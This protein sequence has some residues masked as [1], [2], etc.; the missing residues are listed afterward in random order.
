M[1]NYTIIPLDVEHVEEI[2]LDI[3]EQYEKGISTCALFSMPL[4]PEGNPVINKAQIMCEK[5]DLFR[6]RLAQMGIECGILV[7]CSIGHGY[8]LNSMF[9]F[10]PYVGLNNGEETT[11]CCPYDEDFRE[12][13]KGVMSILASHKP[14]VIMVDDDF[15]LM[16]R[17]EKGCACPM[18]LKRVSEIIGEDITR[19]ELL[20]HT[21]NHDEKSKKITQVFIQT[22]GESL[23]GAIKAM[24]E[25]IDAFDPTIPGIYCTCGEAAEF[26]SDIAKIIAGEGNPVTVRINNGNYTPA[27]ARGL[28]RVAFRAAVEK[29]HIGDGVEAILA[30]T[31][32]C[33]QNRYSTSALSLHSHFVTS[34]LEGAKGAK[35]WITRT[36]SFEPDSG[37]AYRKTL[38]KYSGFYQALSDIV[39]VVKWVGANNLLS[40][41]PFYGF[42]NE[43]KKSAHWAH[44]VHERMGIPMYYSAEPSNAVF[45]D[46]QDV[47]NFSDE[48]CRK[49]LSGT[50]VLS[51]RCA[52]LLIE[53]GFGE[54]IGVDVREWNGPRTS[55]ER[56][57]INNKKVATQMQIQE[58][59][60]LNDDVKADSMVMHLKGGKTEVP[61]FPGSTVYKNSLGG[62]VV[63]FAG[64][65][66]AVFIYFEAFSFLNETRKLQLVKLLKDTGN[67]PIY[68]KGDEEVYLKAGIMK[69]DSLFCAIS[70]TGF[71]PIEEITLCVEKNYKKVEKLS[72]D[73][74]W[75]ECG[76]EVNGD[77]ITIDVPAYTLQPVILKLS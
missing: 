25:G 12:H 41:K 47:M 46:S 2:C 30:E 18:H 55:F 59:V 50:I 31:D 60:P 58:L 66:E 73:G 35:H 37:K 13:F 67:L 16:A 61:L 45:M 4:V 3:K 62:T 39:P 11:I 23:I 14:K 21:K 53:R 77:V 54:Y 33:P 65:P 32:T 44:C 68:Y 19:E 9:P 26:A 34:I 7:Q 24:R 36:I 8:K 76:F 1:Q 63:V 22:Q 75:E 5:Y 64:T 20:A 10:Q 49:I 40:S 74:K 27:G 70:N 17:A 29:I 56:I 51:S 38:G 72:C 52:K 42:E 28:S 69:D 48:E 15:R 6:D 71:D 43:Y 57:G